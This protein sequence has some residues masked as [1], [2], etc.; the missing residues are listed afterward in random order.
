MWGAGW[1]DLSVSAGTGGPPPSFH[2]DYSDDWAMWV[3]D[4]G[5]PA[6]PEALGDDDEVPIAYWRGDRFATVLFR[7]WASISE[8]EQ[9]PVDRPDV[10]DDHY[11]L[12]LTETGWEPIT[13]GGGAGGPLRDPMVR[14]VLPADT[15]SFGGDWLQGDDKGSVRGLTGTVGERARY[16]AVQD[17]Y[18]MTRHPVEAP[19]AAIIVCWDATRDVTITILDA[20]DEVLGQT[21]RH[22]NQW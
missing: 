20:E 18:G 2:Y 5:L 10:Y 1:N 17:R 21:Q 15:A 12:V 3:L 7:S 4:H 6:M 13:A 16:I 9:E 14:P 22:P 8:D 11:S 19:L